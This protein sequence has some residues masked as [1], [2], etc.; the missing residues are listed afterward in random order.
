MGASTPE[1]ANIIGHHAGNDDNEGAKAIA[2]AMLGGVTAALQGNSAAAGAAGAVLGEAIAH[3]LYPNTP[4]DK[5]TE[6]ERQT[7]STLSSI[8]A[9]IT[10]GNSAGTAAGESAGKNA[11]ENNLLGG[12]TEDGQVR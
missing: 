9:G 7:I 12:G 8:S 4:T 6:E 10:G 1:L 5:L 11:V 3:Q 2:H